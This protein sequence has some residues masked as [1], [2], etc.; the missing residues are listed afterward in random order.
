VPSP[1]RGCTV[2]PKRVPRGGFVG[3]RGVVPGCP[4]GDQVTLISRAFP[5]RH[6]FA[7]LPAIFARV[8]AHARY[9]VRAR[10]PSRRRPGRYSITGR[11]GG[12][13]LGVSASLRVLR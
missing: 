10:I 5:H 11:C 3:I 1:L 13:N 12:A 6:D 2:T 7:G 4:R 8:G 9:S